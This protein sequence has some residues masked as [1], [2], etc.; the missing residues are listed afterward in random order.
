[1]PHPFRPAAWLRLLCLSGAVVLTA[2]AWAQKPDAKPL[3][4]DEIKADANVVATVYETAKLSA[5][6]KGAKRVAV[7][8]FVLESVQKTGKGV[9]MTTENGSVAQNVTYLLTEVP[10]AGLQAALDKAYDGFVADLASLGIDVVPT[11]DVLAT[12]AYRKVAASR[13]AAPKKLEQGDW[14]VELYN[15]R[16]LATATES[17]WMYFS[18]ISTPSAAGLLGAARAIGNISNLVADGNLQAEI[19]KE[20]GVPVIAVQ[21]P[22]EFV[23]QS[24]SGSSSGAVT[25]AQVNSRVRMSLSVAGMVGVG[26]P[27]GST[28]ALPMKTPLVMAGQP[29]A[30]VKDTSST[31]GN[32]ALGLLSLALG[33]KSS[34]KLTEKT[35][36]AHPENFVNTVS[37]GL[38]QYRPI[39]KQAMQAMQQ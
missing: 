18:Q 32:V 39:L 17:R 30:E 15:A 37:T 20:L 29:L 24:A 4:L 8:M 6:L 22:L 34:T 23:E 25:N 13:S 31:A 16:G 12:A 14:I 10:Q 38:D 5:V 21:M 7:S 26:M 27:D 19:G 11:A 1:M 9:R 2:P 36:V 33:S 35:A 28:T 3:A